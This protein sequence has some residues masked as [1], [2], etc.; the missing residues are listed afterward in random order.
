MREEWDL[1]LD[2]VNLYLHL[3]TKQKKRTADKF[4]HFFRLFFFIDLFLT[5]FRFNGAIN[6]HHVFSHGFSH[7]H[8]LPRA[9][10]ISIAVGDKNIAL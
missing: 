9:G 3:T 1:D 7:S 10:I 6:I 2:F 8:S 5:L 4:F